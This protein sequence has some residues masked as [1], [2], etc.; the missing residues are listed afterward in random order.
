MQESSEDLFDNL[1]GNR[2]EE[3]KE[4]EQPAREASKRK[5]DLSDSED[6]F[7]PKKAAKAKSSADK[8]KKTKG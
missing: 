2:K 5:F 4:E 8:P 3:E 1:V 6:D 7:A